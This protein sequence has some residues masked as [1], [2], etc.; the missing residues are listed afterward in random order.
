M[1][2]VALV[3]LM[4]FRQTGHCERFGSP[5]PARFSPAMRASMRHVWQNRWPGNVS[6][7]ASLMDRSIRT[8][9][10]C[11]EVRRLVHA[12]DAAESIKGR[13]L[14]LLLRLR[15]DGILAL[16]LQDLLHRRLLV[17]QVH[18][19]H[20]GRRRA[21]ALPRRAIVA[22]LPLR[23]GAGGGRLPL[24]S[25]RRRVWRCGQVDVAVGQPRGSRGFLRAGACA[26]HVVE[27]GLR[28][29]VGRRRR[30]V[31]KGR[32]AV[33]VEAGGIEDCV[34]EAWRRRGR[35]VCA[36]GRV[37]AL[38]VG[39][40]RREARR[41]RVVGGQQAVEEVG[42]AAGQWGARLVGVI[43]GIV[44]GGLGRVVL[45]GHGGGDVVTADRRPGR[46]RQ[47]KGSQRPPV[48]TTQRRQY[49]QARRRVAAQGPPW[50]DVQPP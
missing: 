14:L 26:G 7:W 33:V 23:R 15:L 46:S 43:S 6:S 37:E 27:G 32:E 29:A 20:L 36:I 4:N 48:C 5:G 50:D 35:G 1:M 19:V 10:C 40:L 45:L 3:R 9:G 18:L 49:V 31:A 24:S 16:L 21:L 44:V 39:G 12:D 34:E 30:A 38:V 47:K 41:G 17:R 11:R 13:G 28:L 22:L 42:V 2:S 8:T 25:L